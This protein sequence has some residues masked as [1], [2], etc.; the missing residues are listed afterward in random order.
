[1]GE[2]KA[3]PETKDLLDP[4]KSPRSPSNKDL[5][6]DFEAAERGKVNDT[7]GSL[8]TLVKEISSPTIPPE[9]NPALS[10]FESVPAGDFGIIEES[11]ATSSHKLGERLEPTH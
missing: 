1:M 10:D 11:P 6:A 2:K 8:G 5:G 9:G 4:D 3:D 7:E